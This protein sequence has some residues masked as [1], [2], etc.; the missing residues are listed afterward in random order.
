MRW[1]CVC[2]MWKLRQ[3]DKLQDDVDLLWL[4][5]STLFRGQISNHIKI[6]LNSK[7]GLDF[8]PNL[9]F[10]E[11]RKCLF[12]MVE[13]H[14]CDLIE[15]PLKSVSLNLGMWWGWW[16]APSWLQLAP[17]GAQLGSGS[18]LNFTLFVMLTFR[19][20][21]S[22]VQNWKLLASYNGQTHFWHILFIIFEP[23]W[24]EIEYL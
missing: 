19:Y 14:R 1:N 18:Q 12:I 9:Q 4:E 23:E 7:R 8:G 3:E 2:L 11:W 16:E 22:S 20:S 10:Q 21:D 24:P 6:K 17:A 5:A 13:V 15:D